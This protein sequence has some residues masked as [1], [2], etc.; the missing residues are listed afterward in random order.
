MSVLADFFPWLQ[1]LLAALL[2][3]AI[4]LQRSRDNLGSAFG[5]GPAGDIFHAKRGLEKTIFITTIVLAGLFI[6]VNILNL[7]I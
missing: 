5:G 3:G 2:V 1:V 4:L 6:T 7:F